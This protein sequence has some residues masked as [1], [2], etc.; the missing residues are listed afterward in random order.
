MNSGASGQATG[1]VG[2]GYFRA[3]NV[4]ELRRWVAMMQSH[5]SAV[6]AVTRAAQKA[7]E[8]EREIGG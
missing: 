4:A 7:I 1:S 5:I 6:L 3:A 2:G 8:T